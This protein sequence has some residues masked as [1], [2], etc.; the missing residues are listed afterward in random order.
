MTVAQTR[1][2]RQRQSLRYGKASGRD[3]GEAIEA[4]KRKAERAKAASMKRKK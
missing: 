3:V 1:R 2:A 4:E